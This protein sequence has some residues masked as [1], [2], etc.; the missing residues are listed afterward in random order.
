MHR[1]DEQS[2]IS[3][4][5]AAWRVVLGGE[6][7]RRLP[8]FWQWVT[9]SPVH[10]REALLMG[11]LQQTLQELDTE[12]G[13]EVAVPATIR[14]DDLNEVRGTTALP[15]ASRIAPGLAQFVLAVAACV[16]LA[17]G[18]VVFFRSSHE[19]LT[20]QTYST[21]I[22]EQRHIKLTDGS[23]I[24]LDAQSTLRVEFSAHERAFHLM[25]QGLF[26]VAH[27]PSRPFRVYA[28]AAVV[29]AVGTEFNIRTENVTTVA[30]LDGVVRLYSQSDGRAPDR[31]RGGS[32]STAAQ[33]V[34]GEGVGINMKGEI[35]DRMGVDRATVTAWEQRRLVFSRA[36]LE[37]IVRQFNRYNRKGHL[38][39]EGNAAALRFGGVFD[40]EDPGPLL[41]ILAKSP[42]VVV[43]QEGDDIVIRDRR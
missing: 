39:V 16:V 35:I 27:D 13:T 40:A 26:D 12:S 17:L 22:G 38:R 42:D 25:G 37:D 19:K 20:V 3:E 32:L 36:P 41:L 24:V 4:Q 14:A 10:V 23:H 7:Q 29:E 9:Q 18:A 8:E 1:R 33:L 31:S 11:L 6:D 2:S 15:R 21:D 30:V 28:A 5:A 43:E 34:A